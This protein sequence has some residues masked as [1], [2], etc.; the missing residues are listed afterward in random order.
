MVGMLRVEIY[1]EIQ[2]NLSGF[3][4]QCISILRF[5][6]GEELDVSKEVRRDDASR[7]NVEYES[8][9]D[10]TGLGTQACQ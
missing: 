10:E 2:A 8:Q 9:E 4:K 6:I 1:D 7:W 3:F 5:S